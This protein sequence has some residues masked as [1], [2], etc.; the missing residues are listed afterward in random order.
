MFKSW[1]SLI[2]TASYI[3]A[4]FIIPVREAWSTSPTW[5]GDVCSFSITAWLPFVSFHPNP[6]VFND[7]NKNKSL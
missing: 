4:S 6:G 2:I 1:E 5:L 3:S 7:K